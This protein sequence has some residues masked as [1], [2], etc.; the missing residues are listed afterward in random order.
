MHRLGE[1]TG[2]G[3]MYQQRVVQG[4][5]VNE[6]LLTRRMGYRFLSEG[7]DSTFLKDWCLRLYPAFPRGTIMLS[8]EDK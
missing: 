7:S 2:K 1:M 5:E 4:M 3:F 6:E 8:V